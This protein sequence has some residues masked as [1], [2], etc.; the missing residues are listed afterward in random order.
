MKDVITRFKDGVR[1]D[2]PRARCACGGI[3]DAHPTKDAS[4]CRD[5]G[6]ETAGEDA[7]RIQETTTP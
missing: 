4:V 3:I 7:F 6:T 5:C 1:T 2:H